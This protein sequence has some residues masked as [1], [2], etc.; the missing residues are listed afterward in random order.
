MTGIQ[1]HQTPEWSKSHAVGVWNIYLEWTDSSPWKALFWH[2]RSS[3]EA[4][5]SEDPT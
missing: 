2:Q 1:T 5:G 3:K 4:D